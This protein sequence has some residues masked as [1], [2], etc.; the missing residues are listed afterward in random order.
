M[1]KLLPVRVASHVDISTLGYFC[2]RD[3]EFEAN[4]KTDLFTLGST[5]YFI[6]IGHEVFPG[7]IGGEHGWVEKV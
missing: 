7:I 6:M 1:A 2:P 4:L 5:I 3:D